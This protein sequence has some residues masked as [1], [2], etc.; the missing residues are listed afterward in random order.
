MLECAGRQDFISKPRVKSKIGNY[1]TEGEE[2]ELECEVD[3]N[4]SRYE[5]TWSLPQNVSRDVSLKA[6]AL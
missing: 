2:I 5:I 3:P 6:L 4:S 1:A